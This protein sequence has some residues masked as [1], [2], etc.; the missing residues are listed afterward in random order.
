MCLLGSVEEQLSLSLKKYLTNYVIFIE[1][2]IYHYLSV[3]PSVNVVLELNLNILNP[4]PESAV[5]NSSEE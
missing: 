3:N 2:L 1:D 4:G 5:H